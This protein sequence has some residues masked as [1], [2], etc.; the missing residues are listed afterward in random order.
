MNKYIEAEQKAQAGFWFTYAIGNVFA[1][2]FWVI[3]MGNGNLL[4]GLFGVVIQ[5]VFNSIVYPKYEAKFEERTKDVA[6]RTQIE[7]LYVFTRFEGQ[8]DDTVAD[9][10][11]RTVE[12]LRASENKHAVKVHLVIFQDVQTFTWF[13]DRSGK[14]VKNQSWRETGSATEDW[15]E[16]LDFIYRFEREDRDVRLRE[17]R[18]DTAG[19]DWVNENI[20]KQCREPLT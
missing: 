9:T 6:F 13:V 19:F 17:L 15:E 14:I 4:L 7:N 1:G 18:K 12:A 10:F 8:P 3:L 2:L 20:F 16:Y 5:I 11:Y